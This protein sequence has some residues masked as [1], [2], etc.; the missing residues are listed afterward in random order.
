MG[1]ADAHDAVV[2]AVDAILI[3]VVLLVVE[4]VD[5]HEAFAPVTFETME[6]GAVVE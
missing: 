1:L 3:H 4:G 6:L 5:D 2:H